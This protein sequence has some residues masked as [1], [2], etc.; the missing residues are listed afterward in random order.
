MAFCVAGVYFVIAAEYVKTQNPAAFVTLAEKLQKDRTWRDLYE[1]FETALATA[2]EE[3]KRQQEDATESTLKKTKA[4]TLR[5]LLNIPARPE[6]AG[7]DYIRYLTRLISQTET[8]TGVR[9]GVLSSVLRQ[10]GQPMPEVQT[11]DPETLLKKISTRAEE[12][13]S[14]PIRVW[15]IETPLALPLQYGQAQYAIPLSIF[16]ISLQII[17]VPLLI[18]WTASLYMTRQREL[19]LIR[20]LDDYK[21]AQPHMLNILPIYWASCPDWSAKHSEAEVQDKARQRIRLRCALYRSLIL[22]VFV[23]TMFFCT[24]YSYIR[25]FGNENDFNVFSLLLFLLPLGL[26][27]QSV[28]LIR[29]EWSIMKNKDFST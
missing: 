7:R 16:S 27:Y 1:K 26:A 10:D 25:G 11:L 15:G 13:A 5:Q 17:L 19:L 18:V 3:E 24:T 20:Q 28:R 2:Q 12:L 14:Q 6:D 4:Q 8:E 21:F 22:F 29:Q 23:G 9:P